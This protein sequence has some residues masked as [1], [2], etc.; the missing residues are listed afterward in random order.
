MKKENVLEIAK[1]VEEIRDDILLT[2]LI[3]A[4]N[5]LNDIQDKIG[6]ILVDHAESNLESQE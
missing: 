5:R 3:P 1:F 6:A 4:L 2:K